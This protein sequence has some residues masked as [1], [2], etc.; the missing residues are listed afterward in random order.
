MP[1]YQNNTFD[2]IVYRNSTYYGTAAYL[3]SSVTNQAN[4]WQPVSGE[5]VISS[6]TK[7]TTNY[8]SVNTSYLVTCS[9]L[10]EPQVN[11]WIGISH[12][13]EY[14]GHGTVSHSRYS[15]LFGNYD[16]DDWD[17]F[18]VGLNLL[19]ATNYYPTYSRCYTRVPFGR[20]ITL[21]FNARIDSMTQG[22]LLRIAHD[23][24]NATSSTRLELPLPCAVTSTMICS[25]TF[26]YTICYDVTHGYKFL[27]Y[28]QATSETHHNNMFTLNQVLDED[29]N[30]LNSTFVVYKDASIALS[31][32]DTIATQG[33]AIDFYTLSLQS[34]LPFA[35]IFTVSRKPQQYTTSSFTERA[36]A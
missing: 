20:I 17:R 3:R 7:V 18:G 8:V 29:G 6:L 25:N 15:L 12:S 4:S 9:E 23:D 19:V 26:K 21:D 11:V 33:T 35:R 22:I 27:T 14:G 30:K 31:E 16:S 32:F 1:S 36:E 24:P 5:D 28:S 34:N 2:D 13:T 10:Y